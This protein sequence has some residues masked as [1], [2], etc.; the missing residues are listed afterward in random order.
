[1]NIWDLF[2]GF[3]TNILLLIYSVIVRVGIF[4]SIGAFGITIILFTG[5]IRLATHPMMA[6][7]IRS[8]MRMQEMMQSKEYQAIQKKYKDDREKLNAEQMKLYQEMGINPF[9][10]CLPSLI[11][12]PVMIGLYQSVIRAVA[13]SPLQLLQFTRGIYPFINAVNLIPLHSNFLW[14]NLGQPEGIRLPF[15]ISFL[16]YGFPVLALLVAV[17]TFIQFKV[18]M[19]TTPTA[20][21][22]DQTATMNRTMGIYMPVLLGYFALSYASG[23]GVYLLTSNVLT[24]VQYAMLGKVNWKNL[25]SSSSATPQTKSK[26]S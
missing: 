21:P 14:M 2:V 3:F 11:Q 12:F 10:S 23:L 20:G 7:Q 5:L 25:F 19:T 1:M 4:D 16:P 15:S 6:S 26:R 13:T 8:S 24:V 22:N 9:S 18:T 17:T